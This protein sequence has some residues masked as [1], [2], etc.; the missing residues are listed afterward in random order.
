MSERTDEG[1]TTDAVDFVTIKEEKMDH[2]IFFFIFMIKYSLY[3]QILYII[4]HS[5]FLK[6]IKI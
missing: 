3:I 6:K 4:Y 5:K 2:Y 1:T